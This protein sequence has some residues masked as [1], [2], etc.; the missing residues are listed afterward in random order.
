MLLSS[1]ME[2]RQLETLIAVAAEGSFT[3]AAIE[4]STAQSNVSDQIKQLESE[5][6]VQLFTRGRR[7]AQTTEFG[8][9]V[10]DRARRIGREIESMRSDISA[11]L[12]LEVGEATF[13][14]VGTASRWVIPRLVAELRER[15]SGI[16]LMVR[17]AASERLIVDVASGVL[18]QAIVTEPVND[19]RVQGETLMEENLVAVLPKSVSVPDKPI[20][21]AKVLELGLVLPPRENPL[22]REVESAALEKSLEVRVTVEVEGIRLIADLVAS[23]AGASIMPET[24]LPSDLPNVKTRA[25]IGMPP[26]RL[27]LI[28]GR[29]TSLSS[30]DTAVRAAVLDL[31]LERKGRPRK[32][33]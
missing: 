21:L 8:E 3:G 18:A 12:G 13:G 15:S 28:S 17:E 32:R 6:G 4:L 30:A 31:V 27:A 9:V 26:R 1:S 29:E 25:I 22:R 33:S 19:P 11:R 10:L 5:L 23:G 2:L 24:A 7:G 16:E 20:S 14:I